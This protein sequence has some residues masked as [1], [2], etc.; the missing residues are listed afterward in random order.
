MEMNINRRKVDFRWPFRSV[1]A[2]IAVIIVWL[3]ITSRIIVGMRK[4]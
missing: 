1:I 3:L 4:W 2:M